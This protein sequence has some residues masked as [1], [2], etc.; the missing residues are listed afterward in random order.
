M[1]II[2]TL[3]IGCRALGQITVYL[4]T[5]YLQIPFKA[6]YYLLYVLF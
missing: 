3:E 4:T 6:V 1:N 5:A 2:Q